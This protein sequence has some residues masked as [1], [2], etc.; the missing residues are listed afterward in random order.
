VSDLGDE[1]RDT[2]DGAAAPVTFDEI[3]ALHPPSARRSTVGTLVTATALVAALVV[4]AVGVA[5]LGAGDGSPKLRIAAPTV[6]VGDI[7]LA[8]LS[9][10]F[11]DDG[12]RAPVGAEL[13]DAVRAVAGVAGAQG[14]MQRFV[15]VVPATTPEALTSTPASERSAIAIS[16]EQ[17][18]PLTFATGGPPTARG[19]VA[20]NQ[21]LADQYGVGVGAELAVHAGLNNNFGGAAATPMRVVGIFTPAGGDVHDVNLVVLST[22]DLGA[23]TGRTSFDRIDIVAT[24]GT[25]I[26]QLVDRV[27]AALPTGFMVVPPSVVGFDS[28]LRAELEIQRAYHW[29][30]S[31]DTATRLQATDAP[32]DPATEAQSQQTYDQ[33][34]SA[35]AVTE[36][37]VARVAFVDNATALVTYR[38][39]YGGTPSLVAPGAITGVAVNV[40]GSWRISKRG[41]CELAKLASIACDPGNGPDPSSLAP[42]PDGWNRADAVAGAADAFRVLADPQSSADQRVAV[43][44]NGSALRPTITAGATADAA[45][46][47]PVE[48]RIAGTRLL[49]PTHAQVLYSV[50]TAGDPRF[51]TPYPLVGNAVLVDGSWRVAARYACGL[52]ALAAAPCPAATA[53]Q[54][55]TSVRGAARPTRTS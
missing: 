15:D 39:Y 27:A 46:A 21:S 32:P 6:A 10:S 52:A 19:D 17:D 53:S 20:I 45:R 11:D 33:H 14:A 34:R 26:D 29:L 2:I 36:L 18:A 40:D 48:F 42:P 1:L 8:V 47:G 5:N 9:T 7:D 35:T 25:P 28:Q 41:I 3:V 55:T 4:G 37:R 54:S 31:P 13:L 38:V 43:V 50:V 51:E 16:W 24:D 44:S 30:L 49:D 12:A 22:A 23:I